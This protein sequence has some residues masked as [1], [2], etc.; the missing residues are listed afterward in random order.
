MEELSKSEKLAL[1]MIAEECHEELIRGTPPSVISTI[2]SRCSRRLPMSAK[3]E[4]YP[5]G[6]LKE[7]LIGKMD[8]PMFEQE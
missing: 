6:I 7:I 8:C 3:C 5:N 1:Q 4:A 2:C